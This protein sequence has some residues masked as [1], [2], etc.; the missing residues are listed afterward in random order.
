MPVLI[1]NFPNVTAGLDVSSDAIDVLGTHPNITGVKFTCGS[2]AKVARAA[3]SYSPENFCTMA[4]QGD[5][6][7]PA[8]SVGG[9]G[10]ITG[11]ANLYPKVSRYI[12]SPFFF[13]Y[14]RDSSS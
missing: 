7:I 2:I 13:E 4:G 12:Y 3:A 11:L 9:R 8:M 1:Y 10:C 14:F 6:L 5:W